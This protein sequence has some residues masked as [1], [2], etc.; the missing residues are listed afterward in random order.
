M[1]CSFET[2]SNNHQRSAMSHSGLVATSV[3]ESE[4]FVYTGVLFTRTAFQ[5]S[6]LQSVHVILSL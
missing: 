3:R 6:T 2:G 1:L 4:G 5:A